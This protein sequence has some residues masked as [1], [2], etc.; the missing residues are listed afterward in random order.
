MGENGRIIKSENHY[1]MVQEPGSNLLG[2]VTIP[3]DSEIESE[4]KG[5]ELIFEKMLEF[6]KI[7][8]LQDLKVLCNDGTY[9]NTGRR[10]GICTRFE[11]A[12]ERPLQRFVCLLHC[13]E[14]PLRKLILTFD[15]KS[16]SGEEFSGPIGKRMTSKTIEQLEIL[17]FD[18][19]DMSEYFP[20]FQTHFNDNELD[21]SKDQNYLFEICQAVSNGHVSDKLARKHPGK[22]CLSRWVTTASRILRLYVSS[23]IDTFQNDD[24]LTFEEAEKSF[25]LLKSFATFIMKVYAPSY[26]SIKQKS[27]CIYGPKHFF[28]MV[29]WSRYLDESL[30]EVVDK[31]LSDNCYFAHPENIILAMLFDESYRVKKK[32]IMLI[33]QI[34]KQNEDNQLI[35]HEKRGRGRPKKSLK[36]REFTLPSLNLEATSYHDLINWTTTKLYEPPLTMGLSLSEIESGLDR[37]DFYC[38]TQDV[39]RLVHLISRV[40]KSST[41]DLKKLANAFIIQNNIKTLPVPTTKQNFINMFSE[42]NITN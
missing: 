17:N 29:S 28:N 10:K 14:L 38:H 35:V 3:K 6:V 20:N 16:L 21:L 24:E 34:R 22:A 40:A 19:I 25:K 32:A 26:F 37:P 30:K 9:T 31:S 42:L 1:T 36:V 33:Q 4:A 13:V 15:G 27:N 41:N 39:E 11:V 8:D 7:E 18:P 2:Y 12:L 23:S 5:A